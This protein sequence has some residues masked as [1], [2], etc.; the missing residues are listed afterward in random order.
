MKDVSRA[1]RGKPFEDLLK[2]V[3]SKYRQT[4]LACVHK[5]PT[6]FTATSSP[7]PPHS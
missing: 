1:N 6:E 3:H 7:R 5:V 4:G 2:M